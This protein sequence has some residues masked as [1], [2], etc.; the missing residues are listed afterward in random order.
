MLNKE[1]ENTCGCGD[2]GVVIENSNKR[3]GDHGWPLQA[4]WLLLKEREANNSFHYM[5]HIYRGIGLYL[6]MMSM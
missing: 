5:P 4:T 1:E 3:K 6:M 2:I